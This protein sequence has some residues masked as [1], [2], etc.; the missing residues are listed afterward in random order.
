[1]FRA[2]RQA[3]TVKAG[4]EGRKAVESLHQQQNTTKPKNMVMVNASV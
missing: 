1:M 2:F 4:K 3:W